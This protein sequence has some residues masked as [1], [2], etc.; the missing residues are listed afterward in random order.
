MNKSH[1]VFSLYPFQWH[2][3]QSKGVSESM[4]VLTLFT[5]TT[6][7]NFVICD[8]AILVEVICISRRSCKTMW[9]KVAINVESIQKPVSCNP[10]CH[11][12]YFIRHRKPLYGSFKYSTLMQI[13]LQFTWIIISIYNISS[14]WSRNIF[15]FLKF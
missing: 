14:I 1:S 10:H 9:L 8:W 11:S 13:E 2:G 15:N 7:P 3:T 6:F 12:K 4:Q 5:W